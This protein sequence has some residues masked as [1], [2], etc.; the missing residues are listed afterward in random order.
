MPITI[1]GKLELPL[2]N[3]ELIALIQ[4]AGKQSCVAAEPTALDQAAKAAAAELQRRI[5]NQ[6]KLP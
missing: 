1:C 5:E 2:T 3:A 6:P 4:E